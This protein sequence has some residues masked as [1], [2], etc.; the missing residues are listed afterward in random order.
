[1]KKV[2]TAAVLCLFAW[3][4]AQTDGT[5]NLSFTPIKY[6]NVGWSPEHCVAA[7]ISNNTGAYVKTLEVK[8]HFPRY[9]QYLTKWKAA[10]AH[11]TNTA[12]TEMDAETGASMSAHV[13]HNLTWNLK[14]KNGTLVEDGVYRVNLEFTEIN[15]T[16]KYY[17][18]SFNKGIADTAVTP[19]ANQFFKDISL[20]YTP[21]VGISAPV[22]SSELKL[23]N[24][25]NPFNN[26]C[27]INYSVTKTGPVTLE[28]F[29]NS[30]KLVKT[31]INGQISSGDHSA[32]WEGTNNN[33]KTVASGT[34]YYVLK[35]NGLVTAKKALLIK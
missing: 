29:D 1:M 14:D 35:S 21:V 33:G 32:V 17:T 20:T 18:F 6:A 26:T 27:T 15:G 12:F 19:V 5:A 30:G 22:K 13:P 25:P 11:N 24:Y 34:Y 3:V 10:S 28:I 31:V 16:G 2:L 23:S 4:I 9:G 7:W 8:A